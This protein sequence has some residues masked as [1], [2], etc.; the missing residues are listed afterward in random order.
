M[1]NTDMLDFHID[2]WNQCCNK[3]ESSTGVTFSIQVSMRAAPLVI[4]GQDK[5]YSL[6]QFLL[7]NKI[8]ICPSGQHL[9]LPKS[10]G[11]GSMLSAFFGK[12]LSA[13]EEFQ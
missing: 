7:G 6:S 9:L 1:K 2:Y 4:I 10:E 8:W 11:D 5:A 13:P 3:N 12:S